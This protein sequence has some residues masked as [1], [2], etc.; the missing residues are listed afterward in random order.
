MRKIRL[1]VRMKSAA[2]SYLKQMGRPMV[3]FVGEKIQTVI[4]QTLVY[5]Y[6]I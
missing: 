4:N 5:R 6:N 2:K 1:G 3:C